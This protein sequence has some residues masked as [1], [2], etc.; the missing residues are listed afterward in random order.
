MVAKGWPACLRAI[1]PVALL[2]LDATRI[3]LETGITIS[4]PH[5]ITSL[6]ETKGNLWLAGTR[7][8]KYQTLLLE[9]LAICIETY[10]GIF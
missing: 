8:S 4:S 9:G 6:P 3:T 10:N 7:L 1:A 2:I 5:N